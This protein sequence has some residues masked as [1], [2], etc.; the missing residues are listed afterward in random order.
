V[1]LIRRLLK[2]WTGRRQIFQA[3]VPQERMNSPW[4]GHEVRLRGLRENVARCGRR[5]CRRIESA[6][7]DF[8]RSQR[9]IHSLLGGAVPGDSLLGGTLSGDSLLGGGAVVGDAR[10][11]HS[12]LGEGPRTP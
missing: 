2:Q 4:E 3:T 9:R 12:L 11:G 8:A 1:E 7:A 5:E 10:L 6:Q